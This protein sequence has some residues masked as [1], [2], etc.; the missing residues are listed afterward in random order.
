MT[1]V[2]ELATNAAKHGALS[3]PEGRVSV[4]WDLAGDPARLVLSWREH[5]A[6]RVAAPTRVGFGTRTIQSAI[7]HQL[8]G[9]VDLAFAA[10]G[11]GCTIE[12]PV[13]RLSQGSS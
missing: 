10:D 9:R 2:H 1:V 4:Q 6:P 13:D 3:V 11:V 12:L 5:N 7:S 8:D